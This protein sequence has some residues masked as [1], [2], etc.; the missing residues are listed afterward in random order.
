MALLILGNS[1]A[2]LD[3]TGLSSLSYFDIDSDGPSKSCKK[4]EVFDSS[5]SA[6]INS[7]YIRAV[8][9]FLLHAARFAEH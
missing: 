4:L 7:D 5:L 9:L 2:L 1:G 3:Q 8:Y 6:S